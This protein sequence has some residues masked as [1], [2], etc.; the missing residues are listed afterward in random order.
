MLRSSVKLL[1]GLVLLGKANPPDDRCINKKFPVIVG[2]IKTPDYSSSYMNARA[3]DDDGNIWIGG[4]TYG[5]DIEAAYDR[6]YFMCLDSD[7]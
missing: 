4:S 1:F 2:Q 3:F 6:C 7:N 5:T